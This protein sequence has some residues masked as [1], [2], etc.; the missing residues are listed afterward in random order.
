MKNDSLSYE[1]KIVLVRP[2]YD[3]HIITPPLGLGYLSA[4]L[5]KNNIETVLI[6]GLRDRLNN[7]KLINSILVERPDAVG[8]T[9]LTA[10]YRECVDLSQKLKAKNIKVI[11]GGVHATFLPIETL[12]DSGCDYVVLGEGEKALLELSRN[13]LLNNN[14]PG[15]Y[16]ARD[17]E[18]NNCNPVKAEK[19]D[20]LDEI[21]FPDWEQMP[22]DSYPRA[23]HGAVVKGFPVG[24]ITTTRGCPYGCTFCASPKFYDR[25]IRYRSPENVLKEIKLLVNHYGVKEIH[26]EDD[27]LTLKRDHIK[28]LCHLLI[29]HNV[30]ISW[31]CPN[32]IRADKIDLP[33]VS[34]MKKSGC[35]YFAYG[36][37]SANQEIL[38]NIKKQETIEEIESSINLAATAGITCQGFF[39]F[40]LPGENQKTIDKTISFA[41]HSK[42][43]RAQFII[44]D[45]LTGSELWDTLK[46]KFV[47]NWSKKSYKEPEWIPEG[48]T[49]EMLIKSQSKAFFEF[50]FK[51]PKRLFKLASYV[52]PAQMKHIL[53]RLSDYR[54]L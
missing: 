39:I 7:D 20:N 50:Y 37:E 35:Y 3:S 44:L 53:H 38:D 9:C 16:S 34:L 18:F 17:F 43:E 26:F 33:L 21:P 28:R 24:V 47:P 41:R 49:R 51:S 46:G 30:K 27:N 13:N 8:I 14:I 25:K 52:R 22:P 19:I 11:I 32:G 10:F 15:V 2:K 42:L 36:I 31:A 1:M 29:D 12:R 40:G 45:V 48:M 54:I 4:Y 5:K 6:D 23:P